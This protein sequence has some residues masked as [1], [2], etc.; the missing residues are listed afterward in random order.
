MYKKT[1]ILLYSVHTCKVISA[2]IVFS[3]MIWPDIE[4]MLI[5]LTFSHNLEITVERVIKK[6]FAYCGTNHPS[7]WGIWPTVPGDSG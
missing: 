7:G 5:N 3:L 6:G 2:F 4:F 1:S